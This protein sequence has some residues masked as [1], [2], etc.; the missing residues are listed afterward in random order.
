MDLPFSLSRFR[1]I[2]DVKYVKTM[3]DF[4]ER[5]FGS[6]YSALLSDPFAGVIGRTA[7][8]IGDKGTL[9]YVQYLETTKDEPDY[10]K[11]IEA[12]QI[13]L[14]KDGGA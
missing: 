11:I 4:R 13:A 14:P 9:E 7:F 5:S 8:V 3:S 1:E 2:A 6:R 10:E 12:A